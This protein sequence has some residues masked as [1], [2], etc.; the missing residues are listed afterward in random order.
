MTV[1]AS[2]YALAIAHG[3]ATC[4]AKPNTPCT[5]AGTVASLP[6]DPFP[7]LHRCRQAAARRHQQLRTGRPGEG[8]LP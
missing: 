1:V 4:K 6:D 3:C 7:R 5:T 8:R 2:L